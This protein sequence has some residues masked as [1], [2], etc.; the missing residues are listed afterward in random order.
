MTKCQCNAKLHYY[1]FG[2]LNR[3]HCIAYKVLKDKG[4]ICAATPC[5]G[6]ADA[7]LVNKASFQMATNILDKGIESLI[8]VFANAKEFEHNSMY[9]S[10]VFS[11]ESQ[12]AY[13]AAALHKRKLPY[14]ANEPPRKRER[15]LKCE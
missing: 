2:L 6:N 3:I 11:K 15:A 5:N 13:A 1:A 9:T 10:L 12:A 7:T 4:S 8:E 14:D